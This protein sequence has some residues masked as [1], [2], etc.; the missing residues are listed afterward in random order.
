V[1]TSGPVPAPDASSAPSLRRSLL[2]AALVVLALAAADRAARTFWLE[3]ALPSAD[4]FWIWDE[5]WPRSP[6]RPHAFQMVRHFELAEV[7]PKATLLVQ[8]DEEYRIFVNGRWVGAGRYEELEW[9]AYP[10]TRW[11]RQGPNVVAAELRSSRGAGGLLACLTTTG[12]DCLVASDGGWRSFAQYQSGLARGET[13]DEGRPVLVW[14]RAGTGHW[15]LP[16]IRGVREP[17]AGCID[18]AR[19][20]EAHRVFEVREDP[21]PGGESGATLPVWQARWR[22]FARGLAVIRLPEAGRTVGTLAFGR[23]RQRPID[24][25]SRGTVVTQPGQRTWVATEVQWFEYLEVAGIDDLGEVWFWPVGEREGCNVYY[26]PDRRPRPRGVLGL[27]PPRSST[28]V[29][30]ELRSRFEG[31]P[32]VAGGE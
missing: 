23:K 20:I 18:T 15:P 2:I 26:A 24:P 31:V 28:P 27:A 1:L 3:Q 29:E 25:S 22:H 30:D 11:L 7:P 12:N 4:I 21:V 5:E 19:R 17:A 32:G 9:H 13:D 8:A 6:A 16:S 10:V 14:G